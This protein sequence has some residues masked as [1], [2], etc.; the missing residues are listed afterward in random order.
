MLRYLSKSVLLL[1]FSVVILCVIYPCVVWVIGQ[2]FFPFQANG[3]LVKAPD[4][5][6]VG[7]RLIAQPFSKDEYFQP[8]PSAASYDAS[9]SAAS[10]YAASNYLLRNRVATTLG[11]IVKYKSGPKAGQLAAPDIE[12]W[13]QQDKFQGNPHI[14]AQ[15]ADLH[16]AVAVA[17]ANAD[18]TH[19]QYIDTWAKA[20]SGA[21]AQWVKNNPST[22]Q[23]KATDLAVVFF[24]NFSQEHP[25]MFLSAVTQTGADG[26]P[27]TSIQPV[28]EGSDI[29]GTFF[30]MWRQ[31]HPD[32][33]LQ[34]VPGDLVMASGSGLDPDITLENAEFQLERVAAKWADDTKRDAADIRKEID[35]ILQA[36]ASAAFGGLAGEKFVN[37]LE[38]NLELC[39]RYGAPR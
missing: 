27:Q 33:E 4:G 37:V 38:V 18:P 17:W 26:K 29:Q 11:P 28:K 20:H 5:T 7:S 9:A 2:V 35:Q 8:R 32:A 13:F 10:T 34:D 1:S 3:S 14:V 31:E 12:A 21:V 15:W 39:Q 23:P 30:D 22:P 19:A 36:N 24:E 16:N 6:V 25:G